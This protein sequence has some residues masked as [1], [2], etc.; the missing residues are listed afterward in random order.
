MKNKLKIGFIFLGFIM[1]YSCNKLITNRSTLT[2]FVFNDKKYGG[3]TKGKIKKNQNSPP[4]MVLIE[5]G[6]FTMGQLEN[7]VMFDWNA[8][9]KKIQVNSFY[10]DEAEVT[11]S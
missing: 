9:P 10:M 2:G 4:G 6:A 1:F 11:N 7:N 5:G 3:F 8:T